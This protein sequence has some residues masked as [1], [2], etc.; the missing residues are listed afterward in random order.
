MFKITWPIVTSYQVL[1]FKTQ[2]QARV[3]YLFRVSNTPIRYTRAKQS[4]NIVEMKIA[5]PIIHTAYKSAYERTK[6]PD[7]YLL[8]ISV[9]HSIYHYS[10]SWQCGRKVLMLLDVLTSYSPNKYF[11]LYKISCRT[12]EIKKSQVSSIF[13]AF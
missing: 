9:H 6:N 12:Y 4:V 1:E 2:K 11:V 13:C 3:N 5:P 8:L 7:S 10:F